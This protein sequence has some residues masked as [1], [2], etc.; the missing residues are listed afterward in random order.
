MSKENGHFPV[1]YFETDTYITFL[2]K[3]NLPNVN[4]TVDDVT[5]L[6]GSRPAQISN[7]ARLVYS[8]AGRVG[9]KDH[10]M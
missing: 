6:K 5:H 10:P 4:L 3:Q 8:R 7:K 9:R 1:T 2:N